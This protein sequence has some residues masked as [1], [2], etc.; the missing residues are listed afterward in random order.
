MGCCC[1]KSTENEDMKFDPNTGL[2]QINRFDSAFYSICLVESKIQPGEYLP[3]MKSRVKIMDLNQKLKESNANMK[4][5]VKMMD[6]NQKLSNANM[7]SQEKPENGLR[8]SKPIKTA[9]SCPW[10]LK[11]LMRKLPKIEKKL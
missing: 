5:R 10:I 6:L 2:I 9:L 8:G 11:L 4:S 7:K 3:S 1:S